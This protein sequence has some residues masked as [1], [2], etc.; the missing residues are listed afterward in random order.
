MNIELHIE[1]LI[2]EGLPVSYAQRPLLQAAV[3]AELMR[4]LAEGGLAEGLAGGIM[5]P[6]LQGGVLQLGGAS[7][8]AALGVQI[9]QSVYGSIGTHS[10]PG[11][12]APPSGG[13][14]Q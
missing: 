8:P 7:D 3:E 4:L 1:R 6:S 10:A 14:E 13:G 9:A 12:S 2:V 11:D 5:V